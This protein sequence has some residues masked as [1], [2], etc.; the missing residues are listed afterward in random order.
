MGD[1]SGIDWSDTGLI[2]V[3]TYRAVISKAPLTKTKAGD[4]NYLKMDIQVIDG[5]HKNRH[6]FHNVTFQHPNPMAVGMGKQQLA[7]ICSAIGINKD[8]LSDSSE[9]VNK[10][11]RIKVGHKAD[12]QYGDSEV[13]KGWL[14]DNGLGNEPSEA[15]PW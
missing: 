9:L 6:I 4:G 5:D 3:G 15:A 12:A 2:P 1:L 11:L 14:P 7:A 8:A 10:P 13:I